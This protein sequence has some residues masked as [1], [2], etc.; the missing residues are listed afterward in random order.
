MNELT[1][2]EQELLELFR[3]NADFALQIRE[4][5]EEYEKLEGSYENKP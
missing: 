1:Q 2:R 4:L 3:D 5:M